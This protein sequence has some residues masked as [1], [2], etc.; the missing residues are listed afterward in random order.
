MASRS[1]LDGPRFQLVEGADG[2]LDVARRV[3][4]RR[5]E[6]GID[7][8]DVAPEVLDAI[9]PRVVRSD[10]VIEGVLEPN[11]NLENAVAL[12]PPPRD[13]IVGYARI[14]DE[15]SILGEGKSDIE[16]RIDFPEGVREGCD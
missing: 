9:V 15:I 8:I 1:W 12:E 4:P 16:T 7:G 11:A 3:S 10:V 13:A 5:L 2:P 6:V 14:A